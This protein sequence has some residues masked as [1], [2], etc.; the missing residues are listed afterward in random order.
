MRMRNRLTR[1]PLQ[2]KNHVSYNEVHVA[3]STSI[4]TH[5]RHEESKAKTG[6]EASSESKDYFLV[7]GKVS[8]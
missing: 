7:S 8:S 6:K 4:Q 5:K 2:L 3:N 1:T